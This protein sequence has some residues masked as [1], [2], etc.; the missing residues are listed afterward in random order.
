MLRMSGWHTDR[1]VDNNQQRTNRK[2]NADARTNYVDHKKCAWLWLLSGNFKYI[3]T[4]TGR[5]LISATANG[6]EAADVAHNQKKMFSRYSPQNRCFSLLYCSAR[7]THNYTTIFHSK[8]LIRPG[9]SGKR[10][11][12]Y[13]NINRI[14]SHQTSNE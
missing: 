1:D 4:S 14:E 10:T 8:N 11:R 12:P 2:Q 13:N 9:R 5:I 7:C 6:R 3:H